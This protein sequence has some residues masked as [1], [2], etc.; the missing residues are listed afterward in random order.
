MIAAHG[1]CETVKCPHCGANYMSAGGLKNHISVAHEFRSKEFIYHN[2]NIQIPSL[3]LV[4]KPV[5]EHSYGKPMEPSQTLQHSD[6]FITSADDQQLINDD[7]RK[8][9]L[10]TSEN[11]IDFAPL[12]EKQ[13]VAKTID[14]ISHIYK[15]RKLSSEKYIQDKNTAEN[16]R[17][18]SKLYV[19]IDPDVLTD[20]AL[21]GTIEPIFESLGTKIEYDMQKN[22]EK[23]KKELKEKG[24]ILCDKHTS[25]KVGFL[26]IGGIKSHQF[27]CNAKFQPDRVSKQDCKVLTVLCSM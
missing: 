21:E 10:E 15:K 2:S 11:S 22:M 24:Y 26:S 1:K 3:K 7:I 13:G 17:T 5:I 6:D 27:K 20:E 18:N 19:P 9:P 23:W 4:S 12:Q 14:Y 8:D 16:T 25:Q